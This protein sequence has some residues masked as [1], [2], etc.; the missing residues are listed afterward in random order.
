MVAVVYH[1][2][3]TV[4]VVY[5]SYSTLIQSFD[6]SLVIVFYYVF[7]TILTHVNIDNLLLIVAQ[8][9]Y[10]LNVNLLKLLVNN[11]FEVIFKLQFFFRIVTLYI[12][13][14][15]YVFNVIFFIVTYIFFIINTFH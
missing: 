14:V 1:T 6:I 3:S 4:A 9:I 8:Y 2:F 11:H 5:H 15:I 12:S 13:Y 10:E 7:S